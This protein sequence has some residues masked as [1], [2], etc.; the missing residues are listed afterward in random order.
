MDNIR[1]IKSLRGLIPDKLFESINKENQRHLSSNIKSLATCTGN[2]V[3]NVTR[4]ITITPSGGKPPYTKAELLADGYS[5]KTMIGTYTGAISTT[6]NFPEN[7]G[8]HTYGTRVTDSCVPPQ[9]FTETPCTVNVTAPPILYGYWRINNNTPIT[10]TCSANAT[11]TVNLRI[12]VTGLPIGQQYK[13][14]YRF[15]SPNGTSVIFASPY[16]TT[17][18]VY[19]TFDSAPLPTPMTAGLYS[20]TAFNI[21][22]INGITVI[23]GNGKGTAA[24][25]DIT[26]AAVCP[27]LNSVLTI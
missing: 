20:A 18:G 22:D 14:D 19:M 11:D 27:M 4:N 3:R 9:V 7:V 23:S 24:C 12:A 16:V 17:T 2:V 8:T 10:L 15:T 21:Y 13:A 25:S 6:Y 1:D 26:I 5:V